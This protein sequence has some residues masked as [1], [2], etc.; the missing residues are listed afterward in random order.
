MAAVAFALLLLPAVLGNA[1][2][3]DASTLVQTHASPNDAPPAPEAASLAG[4]KS[5]EVDV[6]EL[7]S[8]PEEVFNQMGKQVGTLEDEMNK[9]HAQNMESIANQQQTYEAKLV[10]QRKQNS[11]LRS[12][13]EATSEEI[14]KLTATNRQLWQRGKDLQNENDRQRQVVQGMQ[15]KIRD[16][17]EF[18]ALQM[19]ELADVDHPDE[20]VLQELDN[21]DSTHHSDES[22]KQNMDKIA[23]LGKAKLSMIAVDGKSD[24]RSILKVM[25]DG[26]THMQEEQRASEEKLKAIFAKKFEAEAVDH[27][28]LTDESARLSTKKSV[29]TDMF[30]RLSAAVKRLED[31][32][33]GLNRAIISLGSYS[34]KIGKD[35][36]DAQGVEDKKVA[37]AQEGGNM[38]QGHDGHKAG[39]LS[40]TWKRIT[41][42]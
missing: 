33:A 14:N 7:S 38:Q 39:W 6:S 12:A 36:L 40:N 2:P 27:K 13:N 22:H 21:L 26:I 17:E 11:D 4:A 29:L 9:I 25:E 23:E 42:K 8:R 19:K 5:S 35:S 10:E 37:L 18:A 24:P 20:A 15:E 32:K 1:S 41:G 34:K 30:T 16:A 28:Q 3:N 31:V